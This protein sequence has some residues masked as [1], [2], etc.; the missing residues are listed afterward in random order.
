M[1]NTSRL[2]VFIQEDDLAMQK[3]IAE[4][5]KEFNYSIKFFSKN[6]SAF[7]LLQFNPDILIQD[8]SEKKIVNCYQWEVPYN[9]WA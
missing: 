7:E 3:K 9:E 1:E 5:L 8:Y 4:E 2:R 6:D